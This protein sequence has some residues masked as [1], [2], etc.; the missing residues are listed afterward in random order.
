MTYFLFLCPTSLI[1]GTLSICGEGVRGA[2]AI[3]DEGVVSRE[4]AVSGESVMSGV[5]TVNDEAIASGKDAVSGEDRASGF[6]TV[7]DQTVAG[8][9]DTK[10]GLDDA[11]EIVLVLQ[12]LNLIGTFLIFYPLGRKDDNVQRTP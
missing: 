5:D 9:E 3:S 6:D 2:N 8:R 11:I 4:D 10:S 7:S 1:F 12:I